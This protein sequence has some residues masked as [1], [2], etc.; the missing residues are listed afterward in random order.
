MRLEPLTY[1]AE[2]NRA[3][4]LEVDLTKEVMV[5]SW[6]WLILELYLRNF[7]FSCYLR[8]WVMSLPWINKRVTVVL[9]GLILFFELEMLD[10]GS[11]L[12]INPIEMGLVQGN[13]IKGDVFK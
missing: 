10:F 8:E 1:F 12:L 7:I 3:L 5:L 4:C 2:D 9:E 6:D 13:L 11:D